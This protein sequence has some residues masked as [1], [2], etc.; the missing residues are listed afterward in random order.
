MANQNQGSTSNRG[1]ASMDENKQREIASQGGKAAHEKGTAHE[2]SSDEAREAGRKG[3]QNSHNG[4]NQS[5][6]R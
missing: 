6:S 5:N 4:G 2:F 3:G 1:F